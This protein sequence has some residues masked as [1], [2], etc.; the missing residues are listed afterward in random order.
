MTRRPR[1]WLATP[2]RYASLTGSGAR[3]VTGL[4][5][6][7]L[8]VCVAG[9]SAP[10]PP[11]A[12]GETVDGQADDQRDILLYEKIVDAVRHDGDYYVTASDALRTGNYPLR[13]FITMRLPGLATLQAALPHLAVLALLYMLVLATAAAWYLRFRDA[14]TDLPPRIIALA[15]VAGGLMAFVQADL[16]AFHEIWAGLLIA[17]SLALRRPGRWIEAVAASLLAALIRETAALYL[18]IMAT[19]AWLDRDRK[20]ALG[21]GLALAIL[22]VALVAHAFA[23]ARVVGPL[24]PAS[25]GWSGLL[26]HGFF[27]HSIRA[28]T[29]LMLAPPWLAAVL[30]GLA[31]FGWSAWADPLAGRALAVFLGY[32]AVLG[33]FA[34]PDTFYW[35]L[36]IAPAFLAGLAFVPDAL[37]DLAIRALDRRRVRVQRVEP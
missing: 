16:W 36:L 26:G 9:L 35:V 1:I 31:L 37:R 11:A 4:L 32:A 30:T 2:T 22:A 19:A 28:A 18:V 33:I 13:P 27:I 12:T 24:D 8:V 25:P 15:L 21:W 23:V 14:F 10:A 34:R 20:E 5:A 29:A 3:I 7:L 17:L 6:L